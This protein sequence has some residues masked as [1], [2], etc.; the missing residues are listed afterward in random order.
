MTGGVRLLT[1]FK[2]V[3]EADGLLQHAESPFHISGL[4]GTME[5]GIVKFITQPAFFS[6]V[7]PSANP[8]V[9]EGGP[10]GHKTGLS[11]SLPRLR[12]GDKDGTSV[13]GGV[14]RRGEGVQRAFG[15]LASS[16]LACRGLRSLFPHLRT[17]RRERGG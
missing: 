10:I 15:P 4:P 6:I 14:V 16:A 17:N 1:G 8:K 7:Y 2:G 11:P 5:G 3:G 12:R 13:V 9:A